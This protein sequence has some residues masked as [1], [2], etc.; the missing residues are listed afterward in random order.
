MGL[1][2]YLV[3][4]TIKKNS[5]V[6]GIFIL[7]LGNCD[8]DFFIFWHCFHITSPKFPKFKKDQNDTEKFQIGN[9]ESKNSTISIK[10]NKIII[11]YHLLL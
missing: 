2:T 9:N 3:S 5:L 8:I 11:K 4:G 6:Q 7:L 10:G 1:V